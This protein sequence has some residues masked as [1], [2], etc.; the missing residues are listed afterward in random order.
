MTNDRSHDL[1]DDAMS[2]YLF[3]QRKIDEVITIVQDIKRFIT[4]YSVEDE[5]DNEDLVTIHEWFRKARKLLKDIDRC[6]PT[7]EVEQ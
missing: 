3:Q 5:W 7:P 4:E 2:S 1:M 6:Y